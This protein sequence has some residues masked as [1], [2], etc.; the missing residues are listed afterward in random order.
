MP[1]DGHFW[2]EPSGGVESQRAGGAEAKE[3]EI[4]SYITSLQQLPQSSAGP[5][6]EPHGFPN[7]DD[8]LIEN[9]MPANPIACRAPEEAHQT[10][11]CVCNR[12]RRMGEPAEAAGVRKS[13]KKRKMY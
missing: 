2:T 11:V 8:A 9:A 1:T 3:S 5:S 12:R 7:P 10:C 6:A 13:E 4:V